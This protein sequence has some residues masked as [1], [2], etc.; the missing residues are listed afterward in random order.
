MPHNIIPSVLRKGD[1]ACIVSPSGCIDRDLIEKAKRVLE[2]WGLIVEVGSNA[3]AK[4]GRFAGTEEQRLNDLQKA[5]ND[6]SVNL[7]FCARGGYGSMH[8]LDELDYSA[9]KKYPKW[10]AGYSD[11]TA[12]HM[13]FLK[14]GIV[15]LHAPMSKHLAANPKDKT[16]QYL[17]DTLFLGG[18]EYTVE[19]NVLNRP[20]DV[21]GVLFGGNMSILTSL[22]GTPYMQVPENGILFIEDINETPYRIDRMIWNLRLSGILPGLKGLIVGHFS[23]YEEDLSMGYSVH[24]LIKKLVK[25]YDYPVIFNFPVGHEKENYTLIQ[26]GNYRMT[27]NDSVSTLKSFV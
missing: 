3:F 27:V 13:G 20:G 1:K 19:S 24:T 25:D 8:L 14:Q 9:I 4:L 17:K 23:E 5:M 18:H 12:L 10:L 11:I 2:N 16:T 7:I 21:E 6:E 22:T 15:S 26:G